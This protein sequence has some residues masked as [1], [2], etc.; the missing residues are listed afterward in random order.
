MLADY[1]QVAEGKLNIIGGGWSVT[2]PVPTPS[3][4]AVWIE[5]PWDQANA[6]HH[7]V[8]ELTDEDGHLV[9]VPTGEGGVSPV[10]IQADVQVGRPP[11][12][13]VGTPLDAP[14]AVNVGPLPLNPDSRFSW[15]LYIDGE[16]Q[17]D[18]RATFTTR[19][20]PEAPGAPQP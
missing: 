1:A 11:G 6:T 13:K 9:M 17:S 19:P 8:L 7:V 12:L 20:A 15:N 4:V 14:F 10:Q 5:I 16:T 18:W 2:G 3:A